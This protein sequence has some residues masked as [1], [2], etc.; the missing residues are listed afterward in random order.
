[1]AII[2]SAP[3]CLAE[4]TASSPTAPS[5]T[6]TTV[7]PGFT[8]AASAANQ[9]VPS[10][11]DVVSR[12]G[13]RSPDGTS[14][15]CHQRPVGQRDAQQWRLRP[16]HELTMDARRLVTVLAMGTRVVRCGERTDHEL[17]RFDGLDRAADLFDKTAVLVPHRRRAVDRLQAPVRPK[18]RSANARRRHAEHRVSRFDNLRCLTIFEPNVAWSVKNCSSHSVSPS[19]SLC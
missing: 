18:V 3:I 13:T 4:S 6:T 10:T 5:P 19:L 1:M 7:V 2:R 15:R 17:P 12:L 16:R 11:S 8:L 14:G 9:P